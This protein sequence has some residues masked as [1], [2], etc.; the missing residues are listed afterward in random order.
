MSNVVESIPEEFRKIFVEVLGEHNA[1]L[2][3]TL[4]TQ[5]EPTAEQREAV[6]DVFSDEV[7]REL[8]PGHVPTERGQLV[9]RAIGEFWYR[10]PN[11]IDH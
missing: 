1:V 4:R 8:G 2:L 11:D 7:V 9:K 3:S 5:D 6:D 10:W